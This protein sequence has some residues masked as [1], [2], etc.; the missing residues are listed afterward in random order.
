MIKLNEV[1]M[2]VGETL[3]FGRRKREH[4]HGIGDTN[5]SAIPEGTDLSKVSV[6]KVKEFSDKNEA[7]K[8]E[9]ELILQYDTINNGWNK[10]RSGHVSNEDDYYVQKVKRYR[11]EHEEEVKAAKKKW[12]EEHKEEVK[13]YN[14][15][16]NHE[17]YLEHREERLAYQRELYLKHK[18]EKKAYAKKYREEHREEMKAYDH[19]KYLKRKL[20]KV[21]EE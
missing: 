16:H 13:A 19:E 11:E 1:V 2:Y 6:I 3:N 14:K 8:H 15:A 12:R 7:L 9:D 5:R 4:L 21:K 10:N 18:E 17:K 20:K